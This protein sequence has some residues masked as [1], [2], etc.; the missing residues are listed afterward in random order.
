MLMNL[1]NVGKN[2]VK[3]NS[4]DLRSLRLFHKST[5]IK[6]NS[7]IKF[8]KQPYK[9][10]K[11]FNLKK[12]SLKSK[13]L[14]GGCLLSIGFGIH[15][16]VNT[17]IFQI[18]L[19]NKISEILQSCLR[20]FFKIVDC[21]ERRDDEEKKNRTASYEQTIGDDKKASG[22]LK[23]E[24]PFDWNEFFKLLYKEKYYFLFACIVSSF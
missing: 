20:I 19:K 3:L 15:Y 5:K 17:N 22:G 16:N 6:I 10:I 11:F 18:D 2:T 12:Q 7:L 13:S 4:F 1:G 21:E 24:A 14:F 8:N 9:Q 23:E